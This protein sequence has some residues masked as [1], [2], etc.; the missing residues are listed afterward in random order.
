MN[1]LSA[2]ERSL[3]DM[4]GRSEE[5]ARKGFDLILESRDYARFFDALKESGFFR[6]DSNPAPV[7]AEQQGHVQIPYWK[8][9]DYLRACARV[10]GED[11]DGVLADKIMAVVRDVS[12]GSTSPGSGDNFHTLRTFAEIMGLLP[13]V[14]VTAV[15]LELVKSWLHTRF[16][17]SAVANALDE[18][19]LSRFLACD[20]PTAWKMA[21][22]LIGYC[23]TI[24]WEPTRFRP[25]SVEPHTIV[26]AY[27]LKDIIGHHATALGT[28][29]G[30]DAAHLLSERVREVFGRG[31]REK[32]SWVFRPSVEDSSQNHEGRSVENSMV[33]GL[34]DV[35]VAWSDADAMSAKPFV[36][37]LLKSTNEML[38][39]VGIFLL[40]EKWTKLK[41]LYAL[42]VGPELFADAHLHELYR[43]L[44]ARFESFSD[45]DKSATIVAL[46]NLPV[47]DDGET[48]HRERAQRRWL[49]AVDG[50]TYKLAAQWLSH[51]SAKYGELP[52][53][54]DYLSYT[55][56]RVGHGPSPYSVGEL[57]AF[58][59]DRSIVEKLRSFDPPN[60]WDGPTV[61][62]LVG[63]IERA[64]QV[65][66]SQFAEVFPDFI[67][68][69]PEY[70][71]GLLNGFLKL[72]RDHKE[73]VATRE[74]DDLWNRL[75]DYFDQLL[76]DPQF[77]TTRG[78]KW[79]DVTASWLSNT[80]S[81][82]LHYGTRDDQHTYPACLL[83]RG[84]ALIQTLVEKG[85]A[86]TEPSHD[87]MTQAINSSKG[88]ALE[89]AF[90]H[91]LRACRLAD[92]ETGNHATVWS[93]MRGFMDH[94]IGLCVDANF[95]FSTLCG[96]LIGN[97]EYIN[98]HWLREH[99]EDIFPVAHPANF[100][101]ALGGLAYASTTRKT[102]CILRDAG[103]MD[104]AL[105]I[106]L[107]GR[108]CREKLMERLALAYLWEEETICSSRFATLFDSG[109]TE[110]LELISLF[111][112]GIPADTL[113]TGQIELVV[114]YWRRCVRWI[115]NL[116]EP[117]A[118]L[119]SGL[120]GMTAFLDTLEG[121]L[122]LLLGV[123]PYVR[124]HH[125]AEEFIGELT[126]LASA[127]PD[128]VR[129]VLAK[130]IE[131]HEPFYDYEGRMR[132]L[133]KRMAELGFRDDA[134]E[135]CEKMRSMAGME[136]LYSE[137]T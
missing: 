8:A 44:R 68:A 22:Q 12:A 53:N 19:A 130:F 26:D 2:N 127:S 56:T 6:P 109:R 54:P 79:R 25:D 24:R 137:L 87:P 125:N 18:G 118:N 134:I 89:A 113:E 102:Y 29:I 37:G 99:I 85:E 104:N 93:E 38:R 46:Q 21:V 41:A 33:E 114:N 73:A 15:D 20:D 5:H 81:E 121:N 52:R 124:V 129:T 96:A 50:T 39:R 74:R 35:L 69:A 13:V 95:E 27:W 14:A 1:S 16:D 83:S 116:A 80:I 17:P 55:E 119:L 71:Y 107:R 66:P 70:Q 92:T 86:A 65:S 11:D 78:T 3:I 34:R 48:E 120:S 31:G 100:S 76:A 112:C 110:D 136:S 58:A 132:S 45:E 105:H 77:W 9:L 59:G 10:A 32:W 123:A 61:E 133:V 94:Q 115:Q 23:T 28:K 97:L 64:I 122:D 106:E 82:L 91:I 101:C 57:I 111:F 98:S 72:W 84:W 131:T 42:V 103:V 108:D 7:P 67:E 75:F 40:V 51:L 63:E 90:S 135:F 88:R 126:R 43:L 30:S 62:A 49:S 4:M 47:R 128:G 60:V 36:L 117:P